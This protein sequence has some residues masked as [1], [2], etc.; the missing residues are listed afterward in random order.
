MISAAKK[1]GRLFVFEGP[2]GFGKTTL[3]NELTGQLA[4][5]EVACRLY[6]FPGREAGS[7]GALVYSL[8]H[9]PRECGVDAIDPS[10]LQVLHLAAHIDNVRSL[11]SPCIEAGVSVVLDRF[12]WSLAA[13]GAALGADRFILDHAIDIERHLFRAVQP[14]CIFLVNKASQFRMKSIP[15]QEIEKAVLTQY[16]SLARDTTESLVVSV[17]NVGDKAN[18]L[19][20]AWATYRESQGRK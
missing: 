6:S 18:V 17:A 16:Q 12:W 11:I 1:K 9:N 4:R 10:S 7:L 13:Y 15:E 14:D 5:D 19:S 8:H 3:A 20:R 2:D